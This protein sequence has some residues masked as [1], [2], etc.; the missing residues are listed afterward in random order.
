MKELSL[1]I[2][3]VLAQGSVGLF[4]MLAAMQL[5]NSEPRHQRAIETGLLAVLGGIAV[6]GVAA[7]SHL[8][9]PLRAFN[10]IFG[11]AHFSPLSV[12]I[13]CVALFGAGVLK[14]L[15]LTRT[16]LLPWA[17]RWVLMGSVALGALLLLAIANVYTLSTVPAWNSG[18][19]VFQFVMTAFVLG[20]PLAALMI[21]LQANW[22]TA[23]RALGSMAALSLVVALVGIAMQLFWLA[24]LGSVNFFDYHYGLMAARLLLLMLGLGVLVIAGSRNADNPRLWAG[25]SVVL[26]LAAELSGRVFFYDLHQFPSGM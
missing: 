7:L 23:T 4:F 8:G 2:F 22:L 1:V 11:L 10:V 25:I 16:G 24:Q 9:S 14:Y 26:V 18:W 15:V 3:T 5:L 6:A 13:L 20:I 21:N 12:E 19:T 17:H